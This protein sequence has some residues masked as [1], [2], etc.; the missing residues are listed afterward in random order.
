MEA[1]G[2]LTGGIAHDFNNMLTGI[3]GSLD[4]IRRRIARGQ[5]DQLGKFMDNAMTS[6]QRAASLTHRLLAFSRQQTLDPKSVDVEELMSGMADMLTRTLGEQVRLKIA[7]GEGIWPALSDVN[8]LENAVLNLAINAR[9]AMPDGGV[10]TIETTNTVLDAARAAQHADIKAGDYVVI[11][12][13]DTGQGMPAEVVAKAFDPF[14][15]TKPIGQGTGLGLST[16]YGFLRQTGGHAEISSE[17]RRGT[18]I[19]MYLPRFLGEAEDKRA[20]AEAEIREDGQ[21]ETVLLVE[22]ESSVRLLI[23][24]VLN[25][26]GYRVLQAANGDEALRHIKAAGP[27]DLM[28]SDVGLPGLNGR[29]VAEIARTIRPGLRVLFV[30]GYAA[31]ATVRSTFLEPGMDLITKPFSMNELAGKISDMLS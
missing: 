7:T 27:I 10:L 29:Q 1:V 22:D 25:E 4:V 31:K 28:I 3:V 2:Q 24:E 9:D 18:T 23:M 5:Y 13:T 20:I 12:V 19:R 26:L 6:A 17:P 11:S 8:Q 30:T 21:G 15:T 14:F 16:V